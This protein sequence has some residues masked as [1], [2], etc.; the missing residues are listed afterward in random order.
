MDTL[1]YMNLSQGL[2]SD[3][4][5][6][7]VVKVG[8][9]AGQN[10][11]QKEIGDDVGSKHNAPEKGGKKKKGKHMQNQVQP[12][13]FIDICYF[14]GKNEEHRVHIQITY[15]GTKSCMNRRKD[16]IV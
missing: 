5:S 6:T 9:S 8:V 3:V 13:C 1:S 15:N 14:F 4:Q 10:T 2:S 7:S 12:K 16:K 11:E